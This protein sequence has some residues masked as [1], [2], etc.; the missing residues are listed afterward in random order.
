MEKYENMTVP[1]SSLLITFVQ[2]VASVLN[3]GGLGASDRFRNQVKYLSYLVKNTD[4]TH[5][6]DINGSIKVICQW[7][8]LSL[9]NGKIPQA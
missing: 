2:K 6:L 5:Y 7:P 1:V 3:I 4:E 8:I 9:E